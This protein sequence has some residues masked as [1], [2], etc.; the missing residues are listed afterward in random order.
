[1]RKT[2][3]QPTPLRAPR[4]G[5]HASQ[6]RRGWL[7]EAWLEILKQFD[8][9]SSQRVARG[10]GL[11]RGGRVRDLWFSPGLANAE[12]VE[13]EHFHVSLRVRVFERAVWNRAVKL[14]SGRLDFVAALLEGELPRELVDTF[15]KNKVALLPSAADIDG[16][17]NCG[18]Y[19]MPC[20]HMA[21][22]FVL[23]ADAL[24]GDPFLLLTLRGRPREQIL[25]SLR[26]AWGDKK[27][28]VPLRTVRDEGP[29][30]DQDWFRAPVP[31]PAM[32]FHPTV[33]LGG[34]ATG[35]REL[36][37][38]P[39]GEDVE[40][41]LSPLYTAGAQVA[42][43]L[44][45]EEDQAPVPR[46][47]QSA[48][49][50]LADRRDTRADAPAPSL[51]FSLPVGTASDEPDPVEMDEEIEGALLELLEDGRGL[52][53]REMAELVGAQLPHVRRVLRQLEEQ[54]R[55][56][57]TGRTRGTRWWL[58]QESEGESSE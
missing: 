41:S 44:A 26:D 47:F 45:L 8:A 20:A 29:P 54:A 36:G 19:A 39:G 17:C 25:A 3:I 58:T 46:A 42:E 23:L 32:D 15:A 24:D 55:V 31:A 14:L 5:I 1:M 7:A 4:D 57:R 9:S 40:R 12:V 49:K 21:A 53:A 2:P 16:D 22:V 48:T 6:R 56:R 35:L 51:T 28:M 38:P 13:R 33:D 30:L 37:P 43:A 10:R 34:V 11:A 18:D 50:D 52:R 27:P